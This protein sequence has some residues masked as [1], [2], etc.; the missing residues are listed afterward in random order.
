M[1]VHD[2]EKAS[3]AQAATLLVEDDGAQRSAIVRGLISDKAT[4]EI[5]GIPCM[6][7]SFIGMILSLT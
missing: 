2:S 5:N 4:G 7:S 6:F 1:P 3:I